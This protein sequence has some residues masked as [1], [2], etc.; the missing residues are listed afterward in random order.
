M[1]DLDGPSDTRKSDEAQQ[2]DLY[3]RPHDHKH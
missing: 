1:R 3:E 2:A